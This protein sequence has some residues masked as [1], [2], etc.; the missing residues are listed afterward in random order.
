M[1][2]PAPYLTL[3][4]LLVVGLLGLVLRWAFASD[5]DRRKDYGLLRE[6]AK[7]PSPG[8]ARFVE[9]RLREVGVRATTVPAEDGEG[10]RVLVF[11]GDERAAIAALLDER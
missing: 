10:L 7:V 6:V 9:E 4:A 8:A 3:V 2:L 1:D 11:P 5:S